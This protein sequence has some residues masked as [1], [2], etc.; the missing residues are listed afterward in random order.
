L[1]PKGASGPVARRYARAL[2]DVATAPSAAAEEAARVRGALDGARALLETNPEL[3]RALTHPGLAAEARRK[4]VTAVWASAPALVA[5][6]L[7]LLVERDRVGLLPAIAE[8][9]AESWN[10]A[11]G[12]VSAEA[13]SAMELDTG[14]EKALV[15][16]LEKTAGKGV[17]LRTRVDPGVLGGLKV[18]MGGRTFDGT[19]KAHLIALKRRLEGAA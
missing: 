1:S 8:A 4:I 11:R 12:V 18:T 13:V 9:Y 6:L 17:E 5:R 7:H 14:Q 3:L 16:A 19:A 2:L 10:A 15:T